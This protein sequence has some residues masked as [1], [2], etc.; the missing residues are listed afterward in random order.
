M[1]IADG[2]KAFLR[3]F[4]R[5]AAERA[6]NVKIDESRREIVSGQ[7]D[8][9]RS[10]PFAN[11]GDLSVFHDHFEAVVDSIRQNQARV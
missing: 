2:S 1:I 6:V 8:R 7:I 10:R 5:V 9:F 4:H 3:R 11:L